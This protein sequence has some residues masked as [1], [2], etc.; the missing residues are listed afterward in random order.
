METTTSLAIQRTLALKS[1]YS[2]LLSAS[3]K[4]ETTFIKLL[5]NQ[6]P[7]QLFPRTEVKV[8]TKRVDLVVT[9]SCGTKILCESGHYCI[10]QSKPVESVKG[11]LYRDS[12]KLTRLLDGT[13]NDGLLIEILS[14]IELKNGLDIRSARVRYP[15]Y[16]LL[17]YMSPRHMAKRS[18]KLEFYKAGFPSLLHGMADFG[19]FIYNIWVFEIRLADVNR[20]LN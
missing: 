17:K 3:R 9:E 4:Y 5:K 8:L 2:M 11:K 6:M 7:L 14:D 18:S 13:Q 20:V 10:S 16:K 1:T 19:D 12:L 15:E